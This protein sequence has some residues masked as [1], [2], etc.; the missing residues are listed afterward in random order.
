MKRLHPTRFVQAILILA[1]AWLASPLAAEQPATRLQLT[2]QVETATDSGCFHRLQREENWPSDKTAIIVCDMWDAHHCYRAVQRGTELAPLINQL[3]EKT[4]PTGVTIIH[5]PSSCME[6]YVDHPAR[7]RAVAV[8]AAA[9]HPDDIAAWC[10]QIPSEEQGVYPIDQSDGGEDDTPEEHAAWEQELVK[11]GRNPRQPWKRQT[12]LIRIDDKDF[13]SDSGVEIWNILAARGIENVILTGVH[14]NMCVLGRPF[15]LRR[16]ASAGKN[17]VLMRDLTDTMYNPAAKPYVSH[18]TGTD[19]IIAHIERFVCPTITSD[20]ILGGQPFRFENDNRPRLAMLIGE[21]EYQTHRTLPKFAIEHLG[22]DY[23]VDIIHA[24]QTDPNTFPGI[25]RVAKADALLLSVRR[26]TPPATELDVVRQFVA[27]GKPVLGIRT[28]SHAFCLRNKP[29]PKGLSDWPQLDAE[30]FGGNYSNHYG[31]DKT[32]TVEWIAEASKHPVLA[33][34]DTDRF[35]SGGSLYVVSPLADGA[36][37]LATGKIDGKPAEPVAWTFSRT[38]G[39]KS[40]YTS[41]GH[42]EDFKQP[43][44]QRLLKQAI[45][46]SVAATQTP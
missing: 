4:R 28:A 7:H 32:A 39:G 27:A 14:T 35:A 3:L 17:V 20:Q 40:F 43:A 45:D 21:R 8:P 18:F 41:L 26:R 5:A 6:A 37:P 30:V 33:G 22:R 11:R 24:S 13:I 42:I 1:T 29:A 36:T 10:H 15:G 23:Q 9:S 16:M 19:L 44:F 31:N 25:E 34:I 46:W 38:D 12:D 2:Y